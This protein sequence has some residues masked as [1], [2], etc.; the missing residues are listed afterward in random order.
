MMEYTSG[1]ITLT[2]ILYFLLSGRVK[3]GK[4]KIIETWCSSRFET[5]CQKIIDSDYKYSLKSTG[6]LLCVIFGI[7]F[8]FSIVFQS[9]TNEN[10]PF[11]EALLAEAAII[12]F[13]GLLGA[14]TKKKLIAETKSAFRESFKPFK[15]I[16]LIL[17]AILLLGYATEK[18][19]VQEFLYTNGIAIMIFGAF[20]AMMFLYFKAIPFI[21]YQGTTI[22]YRTIIKQ[23]YLHKG[24]SL[25]SFFGYFSVILWTIHGIQWLIVAYTI[26]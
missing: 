20:L 23:C 3:K 1:L 26:T 22:I 25:S 2:G 14:K 21:G 15:I 5:H 12:F 19:T 8:L 17:N 9:V 11:V 4:L 7:L 16:L 13:I 18:I 24:N 6:V 10:H